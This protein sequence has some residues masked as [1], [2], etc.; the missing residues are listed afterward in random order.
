MSEQHVPLTAQDRCDSCSAAA[1]VRVHLASGGELLLCNHH[2]FTHE[3]ALL[4][5]GARMVWEDAKRTL[6]V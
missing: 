3:A 1:R 6:T 2:A 4:A 5:R